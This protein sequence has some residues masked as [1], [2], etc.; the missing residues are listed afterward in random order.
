MSGFDPLRRFGVETLRSRLDEDWLPVR[1]RL[2]RRLSVTDERPLFRVEPTRASGTE[3]PRALLRVEGEDEINSL[4][5][6]GRSPR[7]A[8]NFDALDPESAAGQ[9]GVPLLLRISPSEDLVHPARRAAHESREFD[10]R[11][12]VLACVEECD[13]D[14]FSVHRRS[15]YRGGMQRVAISK[16]KVERQVRIRA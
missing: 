11:H 8:L 1:V 4:F 9:G 10:G 3:S 6:H 16:N 14:L 7:G 12:A 13:P 15:F 2:A 5:T